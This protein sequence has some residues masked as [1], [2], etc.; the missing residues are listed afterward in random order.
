MGP[1]RHLSPNLDDENTCVFSYPWELGKIDESLKDYFPHMQE[2]ID[3]FLQRSDK[4]EKFSESNNGHIALLIYE[5][6]NIFRA[7]KLK[8]IQEFIGKLGIAINQEK[9]KRL[10]FLLRKFELIDCT[11][12]GNIDYYY[13]IKRDSKI[14][15]PGRI[16]KTSIKLE[17]H[18]YYKK[19]SADSLRMKVI[20]EKL[21]T[22]S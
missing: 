2:N 20:T 3:N 9:T 12:R 17:V 22:T 6:I 11:M 4:T 19:N 18:E 14:K 13:P 21:G 8:E 15:F 10:L 1:L 5:L 16:D 7:L